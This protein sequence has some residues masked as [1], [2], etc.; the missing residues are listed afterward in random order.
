MPPM[1][2]P[3]PKSLSGLM[4][5]GFTIVAAP[6]LFAIVS[7]AL[8]MNR[9]SARS[10]ELVQHGVR[11][12]RNNQRMFEE[13]GA[14]ERT[15]RLY[16]IIGSADLIEVYGRNEQRL[17]GTLDELMTMPVD[18]ESRNETLALHTEAE[19]L[20]E[21]IKR[22]APASPRMA[23]MINAFP[24]LSAMASKVSNRVS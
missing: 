4:L 22:S 1:R 11:G 3:R 14:L 13:I 7:A 20:H 18:I 21:E 10:E 8:Q 19:R 6:L 23:E 24:Q 12:T 16:Q 15:A 9:L 5:V 2:L 17:I